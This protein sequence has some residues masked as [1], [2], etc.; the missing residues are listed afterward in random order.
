MSEGTEQ[1][2]VVAIEKPRRR[3]LLPT[4]VGIGAFMLGLEGGHGQHGGTRRR[5][6]R[7]PRTSPTEPAEPVQKEPTPA[8]TTPEPT[9]DQPGPQ[10]FALTVKTLDKV[11]HDR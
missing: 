1:P 9:F 3:W 7:P 10:D 4:L 11:P 6:L 8:P 2:T 5:L